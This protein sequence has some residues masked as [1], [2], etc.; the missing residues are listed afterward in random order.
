MLSDPQV[1]LDEIDLEMSIMMMDAKYFKIKPFEPVHPLQL[2]KLRSIDYYKDKEMDM[3]KIIEEEK[4]IDGDLRQI[5]FEI[6]CNG[7]QEAKE[8]LDKIEEIPKHFY[9]NF[10]YLKGLLFD[11]QS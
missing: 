3:E 6:Q 2:P 11:A 8:V 1:I 10:K 9:T 4:L 5:L 7:I